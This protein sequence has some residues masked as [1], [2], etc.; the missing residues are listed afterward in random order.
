MGVDRVIFGSD[1]PHIEGLPTP[2]DYVGELEKFSDQ[3]KQLILRD[4][5]RF[6]NT[7]QSL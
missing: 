2:L 3:E 1:W 4:N 5:A 7:P 6:L